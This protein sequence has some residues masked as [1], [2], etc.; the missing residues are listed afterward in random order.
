MRIY[1]HV[2]RR[3]ARQYI[4][5]RNGYDIRTAARLFFR[6][7][8]ARIVSFARRSSQGRLPSPGK[9][10]IIYVKASGGRWGR[11]KQI[12]IGSSLVNS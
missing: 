5:S 10:Q 12:R 6:Y 7:P 11:R 3:Q 1:Q 9:Y 4:P 2:S 8:K